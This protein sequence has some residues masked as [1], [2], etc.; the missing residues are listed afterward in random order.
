M[1]N[2]LRKPVFGQ[3]KYGQD[4]MFSDIH[5]LAWLTDLNKA[6]MDPYKWRNKQK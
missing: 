4:S 6:K 1:E 5:V 2:S 3:V